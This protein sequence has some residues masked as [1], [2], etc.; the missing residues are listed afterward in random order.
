MKK[1]LLCLIISFLIY[2]LFKKIRNKKK[3]ISKQKNISKQR[4]QTSKE[5]SKN[6]LVLLNNIEPFQNKQK[7]NFISDDYS[8]YSQIVST[9]YKRKI[10][11]YLIENDISMLSDQEC[12]N[13]NKKYL[14]V[15]YIYYTDYT[16]IQP[17]NYKELENKDNKYDTEISDYLSNIHKLNEYDII[18]YVKESIDNYIYWRRLLYDFCLK[19]GDGSDT[20]KK[21]ISDNINNLIGSGSFKMID[22]E[23]IIINNTYLW[24]PTPGFSDHLL[25]FRNKAINMET[26]TIDELI[27]DNNLDHYDKDLKPFLENPFS[28]KKNKHNYNNISLNSNKYFQFFNPL[29]FDSEGKRLDNY[30]FIDVNNA[31]IVSELK[32]YKY[33]NRT[34]FTRDVNIL[35]D[36]KQWKKLQF[37]TFIRKKDFNILNYISF[38][39]E[40]NS[41][42]AM[43]EIILY[44]YVK[45]MNEYN[46]FTLISSD[47]TLFEPFLK[48]NNIPINRLRRSIKNNSELHKSIDLHNEFLKNINYVQYKHIEQI[49]TKI[50]NNYISQRYKIK[51][52]ELNC[53]FNEI[54]KELEL[55][56]N[57]EVWINNISKLLPKSYKKYKDLL[58]ELNIKLNLIVECS[59]KLTYIDKYNCFQ[60]KLSN[61]QTNLNTQAFFSDTSEDDFT[62]NFLTG[63]GVTTI[64]DFGF[65]PIP[66]HL[67]SNV[68]LDIA[69]DEAVTKNMVT[70][71]SYFKKNKQLYSGYDLARHNRYKRLQNELIESSINS[72]PLIK[73]NKLQYKTL[74][75]T[76][77]Q[78]V[79][80]LMREEV[81]GGFVEGNKNKRIV[82]KARQKAIQEAQDEFYEEWNKQSNKDAR[83]KL[84]KEAGDKAADKAR[85]KAQNEARERLSKQIIV[86]EGNLAAYKARDRVEKEIREE[87]VK[88]AAEQETKNK[89]VNTAI[90]ARIK[91]AGDNAANAVQKE[92]QQKLRNNA[93]SF[94]EEKNIRDKATKEA[95][96]KKIELA[97][98]EAVNKIRE[99]GKEKF[100]KKG[101]KMPTGGLY[102]GPARPPGAV[103]RWQGEMAAAKARKIMAEQAQQAVK[104]ASEKARTDA[105][106]KIKN[107]LGN[108]ATEQQIKQAGD[109]AAKAVIEDAKEEA[110][111][112]AE[113]EIREEAAKE[114][115]K[116][117]EKK[118]TLAGKKAAEQAA[119]KINTEAIQK[120]REK[121]QKDMMKMLTTKWKLN[122][123]PV[124]TQAQAQKISKEWGERAAQRMKTKLAQKAQ[125]KGQEKVAQGAIKVGAKY[126]I[127]RAAYLAARGLGY[128]ASPIGW[129][130]A[131]R[132]TADI[133]NFLFGDDFV[134]DDLIV[135]EEE[136]FSDYWWTEH[137]SGT[138]GGP[139][140]MHGIMRTPKGALDFMR[141][142]LFGKD[143]KGSNLKTAL[144]YLKGPYHVMYYKLTMLA[145][146]KL[147]VDVEDMKQWQGIKQTIFLEEQIGLP[148]ELQVIGMAIDRLL[149]AK[150]ALDGFIAW[151]QE[152]FNEN[153]DRELFG[154][155]GNDLIEWTSGAL[156][157]VAQVLG[158]DN[159]CKTERCYVDLYT[160]IFDTKLKETFNSFRDQIIYR[161]D[162]IQKAKQ[163]GIRPEL[164]YHTSIDVNP[165]FKKKQWKEIQTDGTKPLD[166]W[167]GKNYNNYITCSNLFGN[168]KDTT[169]PGKTIN[170]TGL[171]ADND[172]RTN[173]SH[174]DANNKIYK[175]TDANLEDPDRPS[176]NKYLFPLYWDVKEKRY[177][178]NVKHYFKQSADRWHK[179]T[180]KTKKITDFQNIN[181]K[182]KKCYQDDYYTEKDTC[183][184][185]VKHQQLKI[186][187][188]AGLKFI[189]ST[190]SDT[191]FDKRMDDY[192]VNYNLPKPSGMKVYEQYKR[193]NALIEDPNKFFMDNCVVNTEECKTL[194]TKDRKPKKEYLDMKL[195]RKY[196]FGTPIKHTKTSH[197]N[198]E[199]I[200][201]DKCIS[202]NK[203]LFSYEDTTTYRGDFLYNMIINNKTSRNDVF[204]WMD[205]N[206][207][208]INYYKE[209]NKDSFQLDPNYNDC[210]FKDITNE[211]P[212]TKY[213]VQLSKKEKSWKE[214]ISADYD[215]QFKA[216]QESV[217]LDTIKKIKMSG[218]GKFLF[219]TDDN[220]QWPFERLHGERIEKF[221]NMP[222]NKVVASVYKG[223]DIDTG[224]CAPISE[225][226]LFFETPKSKIDAIQKYKDSLYKTSSENLDLLPKWVYNH[227]GF[228]EPWGRFGGT[229]TWSH[230][231]PKDGEDD[232]LGG[233]GV[234]AHRDKNIRTKCQAGRGLYGN[235]YELTA[236]IGKG[237]AEGEASH[238]N[239]PK[240]YNYNPSYCGSLNFKN[241]GL[242]KEGVTKQISHRYS[243]KG[244]VWGEGYPWEERGKDLWKDK[245]E[246]GEISWLKPEFN[247]TNDSRQVK[248]IHAMND[249]SFRGKD[250]IMKSTE[251]IDKQNIDRLYNFNNKCYNYHTIVFRLLKEILPEL[252]LIHKYAEWIDKKLTEY[253]TKMKTVTTPSSECVDGSTPN[254]NTIT[255]YDKSK[256]DKLF[257]DCFNY[258][259]Y[260]NTLKKKTAT[261]ISK[262]L[263]WL[264]DDS[265]PWGDHR[266][267]VYNSSRTQDYCHKFNCLYEQRVAPLFRSHWFFNLQVLTSDFNDVAYGSDIMKWTT[268]G[269]GGNA[270]RDDYNKGI[271]AYRGSPYPRDI[272]IAG[273]NTEHAT[274]YRAPYIPDKVLKLSNYTRT[275]KDYWNDPIDKRRPLKTKQTDVFNYQKIYYN[276]KKPA[277]FFD[278]PLDNHAEP[279]LHPVSKMPKHVED[280]R[281]WSTTH[282]PYEQFK[283]PLIPYEFDKTH[284]IKHYNI[285][286]KTFL[287]LLDDLYTIDI[288]DNFI[289]DENLQMKPESRV[290]II[291]LPI[292]E[293]T[294]K[295]NYIKLELN[296]RLRKEE[297]EIRGIL[298]N[299]WTTIPKTSKEA[300]TKLNNRG[301]NSNGILP[302]GTSYKYMSESY[303]DDR[304]KREFELVLKLANSNYYIEKEATDIT[305]SKFIEEN[306]NEILGLN[307]FSASK[308]REY[309]SPINS[310]ENAHQIISDKVEEKL[311]LINRFIY[312]PNST[313]IIKQLQDL[314]P[315]TD[316][317]NYIKYFDRPNSKKGFVTEKEIRDIIHSKKGNLWES[318]LNLDVQ[319]LPNK[320]LE[321]IYEDGY[322]LNLNIS[323]NDRDN[324]S[325]DFKKIAQKDYTTTYKILKM[326]IKKQIKEKA[327]AIGGSHNQ[328]ISS[329]IFRID[330]LGNLNTTFNG[331]LLDK[332]WG[333]RKGNNLQDGTILED[334]FTELNT[335]LY[336]IKLFQLFYANHGETDLIHLYIENLKKDHDHELF[337]ADSNR[338]KGI[339]SQIGSKHRDD[340][341]PF[342]RRHS[343]PLPPT[344]NPF[345]YLSNNLDGVPNYNNKTHEKFTNGI[346]KIYKQALGHIYKQ[347]H[348]DY[349]KAT[350]K[351]AKTNYH[352]E[353]GIH[354]KYSKGKD[355][356][357]IGSSATPHGK[358]LFYPFNR[359][360]GKGIK[361]V[362]GVS[363]TTRMPWN[364]WLQ[365]VDNYCPYGGKC[366]RNELGYR[367]CYGDHGV[368]YMVSTPDRFNHFAYEHN[369]WNSHLYK[370][371]LDLPTDGAQNRVY[372]KKHYI[373]KHKKWIMKNTMGL[374]VRTL[375]DNYEPET[376]EIKVNGETIIE[377][378]AINLSLKKWLETK[379]PEYSKHN[380]LLGDCIRQFVPRAY[381]RWNVGFNLDSDKKVIKR[382]DDI[383]QR[384]RVKYFDLMFRRRLH[385]NKEPYDIFENVDDMHTDNPRTG[386][387]LHWHHDDRWNTATEQAVYDRTWL[388][389]NLGP[390]AGTFHESFKRGRHKLKNHAL[391]D[392]AWYNDCDIGQKRIT[393]LLTKVLGSSGTRG[394][395][396]LY[397]DTSIQPDR[398]D[399]CRILKVDNNILTRNQEVE[400]GIFNY[401]KS[402]LEDNELEKIL[403]YD[404]NDIA[405]N[406]IFSDLREH[407]GIYNL[408][409][410][411]REFFIKNRGVFDSEELS[412]PPEIIIN[413]N[414][415]IKPTAAEIK[416]F[417]ARRVATETDTDYGFTWDK[418]GEGFKQTWNETGGVITNRFF[419]AGD[420]LSSNT[421]KWNVVKL[422]KENRAYSLGD[423]IKVKL[424][425]INCNKIKKG[426]I[427]IDCKFREDGEGMC[428]NLKYE[429]KDSKLEQDLS[430]E[431]I[432]KNRKS[433]QDLCLL[434]ELDKKKRNSV[435]SNYVIKR[436]QIL[437]F[438]GNKNLTHI[439]F[440]ESTKLETI[441]TGAFKTCINLSKCT[442]LSNKLKSI[443][444]FAFYKC[445]KLEEV[446]LNKCNKL[447][448]SCFSGCTELNK[449][450]IQTHI[451]NKDTTT[452]IGNY[453]FYNCKKLTTVL[454]NF[455]KVGNFAFMRSDTSSTLVLLESAFINIYNVG[456]ATFKNATFG[457]QADD[458]IREHN[459]IDLSNIIT[460]EDSSFENTNIKELVIGIFAIYIGKHAFKGCEKLTKIYRQSEILETIQDEA[461]KNCK[462]L[463]NIELLTQIDDSIE[464][465]QFISNR[466]TETNFIIILT[467]GVFHLGKDII[468]NYPA[469]ID[470]SKT[471]MTHFD[472]AIFKNS[473]A[474]SIKTLI[475]SSTVI[476]IYNSSKDDPKEFLSNLKTFTVDG[477]KESES[478][479]ELI[480][481]ASFSNYK[482]L[483]TINMPHSINLKEVE[484][485]AFSNLTELK[486][487]YNNN[488]NNIINAGEGR[489]EKSFNIKKNKDDITF[490]VGRNNPMIYMKPKY[491]SI[492]KIKTKLVNNPKQ[493]KMECPS[494]K[495]ME[496][497][498]DNIHKLLGLKYLKNETFLKQFNDKAFKTK[499]VKEQNCLYWRYLKQHE[500]DYSNNNYY[501]LLK[502]FKVEWIK[503]TKDINKSLITISEY[504]KN[505]KVWD[506]N[507]KVLFHIQPKL[508]DPGI[509]N[510]TYKK[511]IIDNEAEWCKNI[512]SKNIDSND[513]IDKPFV[514]KYKNLFQT[515]DTNKLSN[516]GDIFCSETKSYD[517]FINIDSWNDYNQMGLN[518]LTFIPEK[519]ETT[520]RELGEINNSVFKKWDETI[521]SYKP[522]P[523]DY[524]LYRNSIQAHESSE[525]AKKIYESSS[526]I[527]VHKDVHKNNIDI[528]TDAG[529]SKWQEYLKILENIQYQITNKFYRID[530][531][532]WRQ[533]GS[534]TVGEPLF[535]CPEG[536]SK[537]IKS[538]TSDNPIP[539]CV[540]NL[541]MTSVCK[542]ATIPTTM[543]L[544]KCKYL[545]NTFNTNFNGS[546]KCVGIDFNE[547]IKC[548]NSYITKCKNEDKIC[549]MVQ[550]I[551]NK[552]NTLGSFEPKCYEPIYNKN[553]CLINKDNFEIDNECTDSQD[554]SIGV[555]NKCYN[556]LE[557]SENVNSNV[558]NIL[559]Y[560]LRDCDAP[561][562][563]LNSHCNL[564]YYNTTTKKPKF[565]KLFINQETTSYNSNSSKCIYNKRLNDSTFRINK[566]VKKVDLDLDVVEQ[567]TKCI[568]GYTIESID[569]C[570]KIIGNDVLVEYTSNTY[571]PLGCFKHNGK[572]FFNNTD[573]TIK[574]NPSGPYMCKYTGESYIKEESWNCEKK[575]KKNECFSKFINGCSKSIITNLW[576]K[577]FDNTKSSCPLGCYEKKP[578]G[579]THNRLAECFTLGSD[580][581][582]CGKIKCDK[583]YVGI[584][585]NGEKKCVKLSCENRTKI[586][587]WT[588]N[589]KNQFS[590]DEYNC[591]TGCVK[592]DKNKCVE[593]NETDVSL[594]MDKN[595]KWL[596]ENNAKY[597]KGGS[598]NYRLYNKKDTTKESKQNPCPN[599]Y[600][601]DLLD[602]NFYYCHNSSKN[603]NDHC[604]YEGELYQ[605]NKWATRTILADYYN[606]INKSSIE[607]KEMKKYTKNNFNN[608]NKFL[609]SNNGITTDCNDHYNEIFNM[610]YNILDT[611]FNTDVCTVFNNYF[612]KNNKMVERS[613]SL[614]YNKFS[615]K[616]LYC[617]DK[618]KD[619]YSTKFNNF[620]E[621]NNTQFNNFIRIKE[622]FSNI[623]LDDD[624]SFDGT[625]PP[626]T[627]N[628]KYNVNKIKPDFI[629]DTFYNNQELCSALFNK[630]C[631]VQTREYR[632]KSMLNLDKSI[633]LPSQMTNDEKELYIEDET[634]TTKDYTYYKKVDLGL[635]FI[636]LKNKIIDIKKSLSSHSDKVPHFFKEKNGMYSKYLNSTTTPATTCKALDDKNFRDNGCF[637]VTL[638]KED[639]AAPNTEIE[640]C[641]NKLTHTYWDKIPSDINFIKAI[642]YTDADNKCQYYFTLDESGSF[643]KKSNGYKFK[644][645][646]E[647]ISYKKDTQTLYKL[648]NDLYRKKK[649][650][651]TSTEP[652]TPQNFLDDT[653]ES[654][655]V[656]KRGSDYKPL[657][658]IKYKLSENCKDDY[659]KINTFSECKNAFRY[660]NFNKN[661]IQPKDFNEFE[662]G[663]DRLSI[664]SGCVYDTNLKKIYF[665]G[666]KTMSMEEKKTWRNI[667]I[668]KHTPPSVKTS[669]DTNTNSLGDSN[670]FK[671][672]DGKFITSDCNDTNFIEDFIKRNKLI[673]Y[674]LVTISIN[675]C[676]A[677]LNTIFDNC[678]LL[679]TIGGIETKIDI[680]DKNLIIINC[681]D[682]NMYNTYIDEHK[683]YN[684][685]KGI[686]LK[687]WT[688]VSAISKT[689]DGKI[690]LIPNQGITEILN[691]I[692]NKK[693]YKYENENGDNNFFIVYRLVINVI[694]KK[695]TP[696]KIDSSYDF[697][698]YFKTSYINS[699]ILDIT[700]KPI[701]HKCQNEYTP[702]Y[703]LTDCYNAAKSIG[704]VSGDKQSYKDLNKGS[705]YF[706]PKGVGVKIGPVRFNKDQNLWVTFEEGTLE[707]CYRSEDGIVYYNNRKIHKDRILTRSYQI[708]GKFQN[709]LGGGKGFK[710]TNSNNTFKL[711]YDS[712]NNPKK[713]GKDNLVCKHD[714][715][716][717]FV[718]ERR[719]QHIKKEEKQ[720]I[721]TTNY[722][723]NNPRRFEQNWFYKDKA[724]R[725]AKR[726]AQQALDNKWTTSDEWK[727]WE[728]N[729]KLTGNKRNWTNNDVVAVTNVEPLK[730]CFDDK[731]KCNLIL[732]TNTDRDFIGWKPTGPGDSADFIKKFGYKPSRCEVRFKKGCYSGTW[733]NYNNKF[734]ISLKSIAGP[735]ENTW[736]EDEYATQQGLCDANKVDDRK[737]I[738]AYRCN[739]L[740]LKKIKILKEDIE[741]RKIDN[742]HTRVLSS[743][744]R[745]FQDLLCSESNSFAMTCPHLCAIKRKEN[746]TNLYKNSIVDS[747]K[748]PK[749]TRSYYLEPFN[750]LAKGKEC[751]VSPGEKIDGN[752]EVYLGNF[753][754]LEKCH[755]ACVTKAQSMGKTCQY[756]IYGQSGTDR[757]G[758]CW[759]E[760]NSCKTTK[761]NKYDI[762]KT[763]TMEKNEIVETLNCA[764]RKNLYNELVWPNPLYRPPK[765]VPTQAG[766][767]IL[768]PDGCFPTSNSRNNLFG[769]TYEH[770][771]HK[772]T[773]IPMN[774]TY[775]VYYNQLER[776]CSDATKKI[777]KHC[778]VYDYDSELRGVGTGAGAK[779]G[780]GPLQFEKFIGEDKFVIRDGNCALC[781]NKVI[782]KNTSL[783]VCKNICQKDKYCLSVTANNKDKST[784]TLHTT[785][786]WNIPSSSSFSTNKFKAATVEKITPDDIVLE[787]DINKVYGDGAKD[788]TCHIKTSGT[789]I[790]N[791]KPEKPGCYVLFPTGCLKNSNIAK[792]NTWNDFKDSKEGDTY[793]STEKNC[794][795][796][797]KTKYNTLCGI[798]NTQTHYVSKSL[799]FFSKPSSWNKGCINTTDGTVNKEQ[800]IFDKCKIIQLLK[801]QGS[802]TPLGKFNGYSD[803]HAGSFNNEHLGK[804]TN[805]KNSITIDDELDNLSRDKCLMNCDKYEECESVTIQ[806]KPKSDYAQP[807]DGPAKSCK[808]HFKNKISN[809]SISSVF[810]NKKWDTAES[811]VKNEIQKHKF[812]GCYKDDKDRD[813]KHGPTTPLPQIPKQT[814]TDGMCNCKN[815][816]SIV[817]FKKEEFNFDTCLKVC[818][819]DKECLAVTKLK[820]GIDGEDN[821]CQLYYVDKNKA[822]FLARGNNKQLFQEQFGKHAKVTMNTGETC[823]SNK[824]SGVSAQSNYSCHNLDKHKPRLMGNTP[825]TCSKACTNY[826]YFSLQN[827]GECFCGNDYSTQKKYSRVIDSECDDNGGR[828]GIRLGG[829]WKNAVFRNSLYSGEGEFECYKK[830][831]TKRISCYNT[832]N[833]IVDS[834]LRPFL[835]KYE[836]EKCTGHG[837]G[838]SK[839][840][841]NKYI[842]FFYGNSIQ[843]ICNIFDTYKSQIRINHTYKGCYKDDKS[844]DLANGPG[845][846]GGSGYTQD[847][848]SQACP[849]YKYFALQN[850]GQCF[851]GDYY[852][853]DKTKYTKISDTNCNKDFS[854]GG[855]LW[856]NAIFENS[857]YKKPP[858]LE[859]IRSVIHTDKIY[860]SQC[861]DTEVWRA[862]HDR[863]LSGILDRAR[864]AMQEA[865]TDKWGTWWKRITCLTA[866]KQGLC[867]TGIG[868]K[869]TALKLKQKGDPLSWKGALFTKDMEIGQKIQAYINCPITCNT[870]EILC[871]N[872]YICATNYENVESETDCYN[873]AKSLGQVSGTQQSYEDQTRVIGKTSENP[874]GSFNKN[875]NMWVTDYSKDPQGCYITKKG[876]VYFNSKKALDE[877]IRVRGGGGWR[878][879][880]NNIF[881][882]RYA[883]L[884]H[885]HDEQTMICKKNITTTTTTTT[886]TREP[887]SEN[888]TR[889]M[890]LDEGG[891]KTNEKNCCLA[892]KEG[893]W[894]NP[895][896]TKLKEDNFLFDKIPHP[897]INYITYDIDKNWCETQLKNDKNFCKYDKCNEIIVGYKSNCSQSCN[898]IRDNN[899]NI[900]ISEEDIK[901]C[902]GTNLQVSETYNKTKSLNIIQN[903]YYKRVIQYTQKCSTKKNSLGGKC[904]ISNN[905]GNRVCL[906]PWNKPRNEFMC[907]N[908]STFNCPEK[909]ETKP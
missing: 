13:N 734:K 121:G 218:G 235:L 570:R 370:T 404:F 769:K 228:S 229:S 222:N 638:E 637:S 403:D 577:P 849:N 464:P 46:I 640:R 305:F 317:V 503:D 808:Y 805:C 280:I 343:P 681:S 55:N 873:I 97:K 811:C 841:Y 848:C 391:V 618:Y 579:I 707:G 180:D 83:K 61:E 803:E 208:Y 304:V 766:C 603:S 634:A 267:Y 888:I 561:T 785:A 863:R 25:Y 755:K 84:E 374:K 413:H 800:C 853:T 144:F 477:G 861:K 79:L 16:D 262:K 77:N 649:I 214:Y 578:E 797:Q 622:K 178:Y 612:A 159:T 123:N 782:V 193:Y 760:N 332:V 554:D 750:L 414:R 747:L 299:K 373:N 406:T 881:K 741:I 569:D 646:P 815:Y 348:E 463:H 899:N 294:I 831:K 715:I 344:W 152:D 308:T 87:A 264:W 106:T 458:G 42:M 727:N 722:I 748:N 422:L 757:K 390:V 903:M 288:K 768:L 307:F 115:R 177:I 49:A 19:G 764:N 585:H 40:G 602:K 1:I 838:S 774:H 455:S 437:T 254:K 328:F 368:R 355:N 453:C 142:S 529:S 683:K 494:G 57:K 206:E 251:I 190:S 58:D 29:V 349:K 68:I 261:F 11:S 807:R 517:K 75:K 378:Q 481:T 535:I 736:Y 52:N 98:K 558:P 606:K 395:G 326:E 185:S 258:I 565:D 824:I 366:Q 205:E 59:T 847:T 438:F 886:T 146:E 533:S 745:Q 562:K 86:S 648:N 268:Y 636:K 687:K 133:A 827:G 820:S 112:N 761:K 726:E 408:K 457:R 375:V 897:D 117:A 291:P 167:M 654:V 51:Y 41:N 312:Y 125:K 590:F 236:G 110:K 657:K 454:I 74:K 151:S 32:K 740:P 82:I 743:Y 721:D 771:L 434:T 21:T 118:G 293:L 506:N 669:T 12:V 642:S 752:D 311:K 825:D 433:D 64:I 892:A 644:V 839:D 424:A 56:K 217:A 381:R 153:F 233:N 337:R 754:S 224:K 396:D 724:F 33:G 430:T 711:Y 333:N 704:Q 129:Y 628:N 767:Y 382:A 568:D 582:K 383:T 688:I 353:E 71:S 96:D 72:K 564:Y 179:V 327:K 397:S 691:D 526:D 842:N 777:I 502:T 170:K 615:T 850:G 624:I 793:D 643:I 872:T 76:K 35:K 175:L 48:L 732:D 812:I 589:P 183:N 692:N 340:Y 94:A 336:M 655:Y 450:E 65:V 140:W 34:S 256:Y 543:N 678:T 334:G 128:V 730:L 845:E 220:R 488:N 38:D 860:N 710:S 324:L 878:T 663:Y 495:L 399:G 266:P 154:L 512:D 586:K 781:N 197:G 372:I 358:G 283:H 572:W 674:K 147:G 659:K 127:S 864:T 902:V 908:I 530:L 359:N 583:G 851:C 898:H 652:I 814:I 99:E 213:H 468:Y 836:F 50:A 168:L 501:K 521:Y 557:G 552:T 88:K 699:D 829:I 226:N 668:K 553:K 510:R 773:K 392:T 439:Y 278:Q 9:F 896:L 816:I 338:E 541:D 645:F 813:L 436:I 470:L 407:R 810:Y 545:C 417:K 596:E 868:I 141:F 631:I 660:F 314:F 834:K 387:G 563:Y 232:W 540:L 796:D 231:N 708:S 856:A 597:Y 240:L 452:H 249:H 130:L 617:K 369:I 362:P 351:I 91:S 389:M 511:F 156:K 426:T 770:N 188:Q 149:D 388:Q 523:N 893:K 201:F 632:K 611:D 187:M 339:R 108:N 843:N 157:K 409:I 859:F 194:L 890:C 791:K 252:L 689:D 28:Y 460:F 601:L 877:R 518:K 772:W 89:A 31:N 166:M 581:I 85:I 559:E 595:S 536:C 635:F 335:R 467:H 53:F 486:N 6:E 875:R 70:L 784:C 182:Y 751:V 789:E 432:I 161:Y 371:F 693:K 508:K 204:K 680:E 480:K 196:I 667:C 286:H 588:Y 515:Y 679:K 253:E 686:E 81:V 869:E 134:N 591:P 300:N 739:R 712:S 5:N 482:S 702:I 665:D 633:Y 717:G 103:Q 478:A 783:E 887:Q 818:N 584:E 386:Y 377:S 621:T 92:T 609:Y 527:C 318:N 306:R 490:W 826:K 165:Y 221:K 244:G 78:K 496:V 227:H 80:L 169:N 566:K 363:G 323:V 316:N 284:F 671:T 867:P 17:L 429:T 199:V 630:K 505:I 124:H 471:N 419:S 614:I 600:K 795:V 27:D 459:N 203:P 100:A 26:N 456:R 647:F 695:Y 575:Y 119:K 47:F 347:T 778:N 733:R 832:C 281:K 882:I 313:E 23:L 519:N 446:K 664:P 629:L 879:N 885:N 274:W 549:R 37:N 354:K 402:L 102:G 431:S 243:D 525:T 62:E 775:E 116:T 493:N 111:E 380:Q 592:F 315:E 8:V 350:E 60:N 277:I 823:I 449:I 862:P 661:T 109:D 376:V 819:E 164:G 189:S 297:G 237:I 718:E 891:Y 498:I 593:I 263:I 158:W 626:R 216:Q 412:I 443:G 219:S 728:I 93:T 705:T 191:S 500:D 401:V 162:L 10:N 546:S 703:S 259:G 555:E 241:D 290:E 122:R 698:N 623:D 485:N 492:I 148:E 788:K 330:V 528:F 587:E 420:K 821:F 802:T 905:N 550:K 24:E 765:E 731:K 716:Q 384:D 870:K 809:F 880:K 36:L 18:V 639:D 63:P 780:K 3:Q 489:L 181:T 491:P 466:M 709:F 620:I 538:I 270:H 303:K 854:L 272:R 697:D 677:I 607:N 234:T 364:G 532:A 207:E 173:W 320:K 605:D 855:G 69:L 571:G 723:Q 352:K 894:L 202:R 619:T 44:N 247:R 356:N 461:F 484:S 737:K 507:S 794:L 524:Y 139:E 120:A 594:L 758:R 361:C 700:T 192:N 275:D 804:C 276:Y 479:L 379:S 599:N 200:K 416:E 440:D 239:N 398:V 309:F 155:S 653:Y 14:L 580:T 672:L 7:T 20:E 296:N 271:F 428:S 520:T 321:E 895:F 415:Y 357:N 260:G 279:Y 230:S 701:V 641:K 245:I 126:M 285:W 567:P 393:E 627:N 257:T 322:K 685:N 673:Y 514:L 610:M 295:Y 145:L 476:Q 906:S 73:A 451:N 210:S 137:E 67:V 790:P 435:Y 475:I 744:K 497:K 865:D 749:W 483:E 345:F 238:M 651:A 900:V 828:K 469:Y 45:Y 184:E 150:K 876:L 138:M 531:N 874:L 282:L 613:K 742:R 269:G 66:N 675:R 694:L 616:F 441:E 846:N 360:Q 696:N 473:S 465:S 448:D 246:V 542:V 909:S 215:S 551:D 534:P 753:N 706:N 223:Y 273:W 822:A 901:N 131:Y 666:K 174:D 690:E 719:T 604:T 738:W 670:L 608:C 107:E 560:R 421:K 544:D 472:M 163:K 289:Y 857:L 405:T 487:I 136:I 302:S 658:I 713:V 756:F 242:M 101:L 114:A 298:T 319:L 365:G 248:N 907:K 729:W 682:L 143:G 39:E 445:T 427:E 817:N 255:K 462:N 195:S 2:I 662:I 548:S 225:T 762:Y 90:E 310:N 844:R 656:Q 837:F 176:T 43:M 904:S 684:D 786:N 331:Y 367:N 858:T 105:E 160:R 513:P 292:D 325:D 95:T 287:D 866:K 444:E 171:D 418:L 573:T 54:I 776:G 499:L 198:E 806:R 425:P 209:K 442:I 265:Y 676:I 346:G 474:Q 799:T 889:K 759:W 400:E 504:P 798:T 22:N 884:L 735:A 763:S 792:E 574:K 447:G 113:K 883:A 132:D 135:T 787:C 509:N 779:K 852:A 385:E 411:D 30:N 840:K 342:R 394:S 104:R 410:F 714:F 830:N 250:K 835:T 801:D 211:D 725:D 423:T 212:N 576:E 720:T 833:H 522:C 329:E 547:N 650:N 598:C 15:D 871:K 539:K 301:P 746:N 516:T 186:K 172:P 537:S 4:I 625:T 556:N 341:D